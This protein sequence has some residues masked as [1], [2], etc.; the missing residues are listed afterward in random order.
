MW[1]VLS[2]DFDANLTEENCLNNVLLN[3]TAGSIIVFHDSQKAFEKL[4]FTL[5]KV[6]D[7]FSKKGYQFKSLEPNIFV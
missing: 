4:T 2:G 6:L 3:T 1:D 7:F 5:P